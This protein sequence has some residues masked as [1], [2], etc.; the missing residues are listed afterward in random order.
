[1]ALVANALAQSAVLMQGDPAPGQPHR[2]LPGNR[3]SS[4]LLLKRLSPRALGQLIALYEHKV[5]VEGVIWNVNSFDQWGVEMGKRLA[6]TL[7]PRLAAGE[8]DPAL[9]AST[10]ALLARLR[11]R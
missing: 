2:V 9:D 6:R 11:E 4:L 5:F 7:L 8:D 1:M 3:P 10:R